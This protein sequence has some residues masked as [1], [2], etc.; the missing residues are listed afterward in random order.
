MNVLNTLFV[1]T[2]GAYVTKDH[3]NLVVKVDG[4][5]RIRVPIHGLSSVVCF[6]HTL[7]SPDA[8]GSAAASGVQMSFF[9]QTGRFVAR[10]E[11]VGRGSLSLRR[12]QLRATDDEAA[13]HEIARSIVLGKIAN[14]R[15]LLLRRA[16]EADDPERSAKLAASADHLA[17]LVPSLRA[18]ETCDQIRGYEGDAAAHYFGAFSACI[19]AKGFTFERRSRRPPRDRVNALLS[20]AYAI[21]LNDC[22][23]ALAGI[24]LDPD[25][26]FLH[27]DRPGRPSLG[28]DLMEELRSPFADRLVLAMLNRGQ[29]RPAHFTV[30]ATGG[31]SLKDG[32]RRDFLASYQTRK[33]EEVSHPFLQRAVPWALVPHLQARL[34]AR[35]LRGDL[36]AYP[37]FTVR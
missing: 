23:A 32:A 34:L 9:S 22:V 14:S 12:A 6:G 20:F 28:L 10:V 18:A 21:L 2:P 8:M 11:G 3:R 29:L 5:P 27:R 24:G 4:E 17:R 19:S 31:V 26:G 37:P 7:V 15:Q 33:Q 1:L 35:H 30:E 36:D 16:R 13:T 25:A